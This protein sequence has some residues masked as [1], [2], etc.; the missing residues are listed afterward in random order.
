[1]S[2]NQNKISELEQ[3]IKKL[4]PEKEYTHEFICALANTQSYIKNNLEATAMKISME[5]GMKH[6]TNMLGGR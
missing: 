4:M 5:A 6:L 1:M 2:L 3:E